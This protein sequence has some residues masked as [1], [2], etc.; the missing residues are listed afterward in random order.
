MVTLDVAVKIPASI[1]YTSVEDGAILLNTRT[2]KYY[3]LNEVGMGF[4][5]HLSSGKNCRECC[6]TL[7]KE[8]E[9]DPAQLESDLVH[10]L[11]ALVENGLLEIDAA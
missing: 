2:N 9:V 6:Q 11:E 8:F 1:L 7:L 5:K 3:S 4:W 10:L